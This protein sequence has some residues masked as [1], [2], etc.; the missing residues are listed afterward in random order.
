MWHDNQ[1]LV[2]S[3]LRRSL[4]VCLSWAQCVQS[5]TPRAR[6]SLFT[7]SAHLDLGLPWFFLPLGLALKRASCVLL[8][9]FVTFRTSLYRV[10]G[11]TSS[12]RHHFRF[13]GR[14][15]FREHFSQIRAIGSPLFWSTPTSHCRRAGLGGSESCEWR[16]LSG[17]KDDSTVDVCTI[18]RSTHLQSGFFVVFPNSRYLLASLGI[19]GTQIFWRLHSVCRQLPRFSS[20]YKSHHSIIPSFRAAIIYF[21]FCSLIFNPTLAASSSNP[22]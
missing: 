13:S 8:F 21:V 3:C 11:C 9:I 15:S 4:H 6:L 12:F 10:H 1:Y 14:I 20:R 5:L 19:L 22:K 7:P 17:V 2:K 18:R 16:I